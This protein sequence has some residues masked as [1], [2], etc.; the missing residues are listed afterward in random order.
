MTRGTKPARHLD[1]QF[2]PASNLRKHSRSATRF[3][4]FR[5]KQSTIRWHRWLLVNAGRN[6]SL[7]HGRR[8]D[9]ERGCTLPRAVRLLDNH[10]VH[11]DRR[12]HAKYGPCRHK[13]E[14]HASAARSSSCAGPMCLCIKPH[15]SGGRHPARFRDHLPRRRAV[16]C[17]CGRLHDFYRTIFCCAW[18]RSATQRHR[19]DQSPGSR[20][21]IHGAGGPLPARGR[22]AGWGVLPFAHRTTVEHAAGLRRAVC[23]AQHQCCACDCFCLAALDPA[24]TQPIHSLRSSS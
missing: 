8:A 11:S 6:C 10:R 7:H 21:V 17:E 9:G 5:A 16:G 12:L 18:I 22:I 1:R 19:K 13:G 14:R 2:E 4:D 24:G 3:C 15:L 23:S 20:L